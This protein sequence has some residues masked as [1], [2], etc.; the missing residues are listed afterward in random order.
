MK[1]WQIH[2]LVMA[3]V[4]FCTFVIIWIIVAA[5]VCSPPNGS[6]WKSCITI[7]SSPSSLLPVPQTQNG[8]DTMGRKHT[9]HIVCCLVLCVCLEC[10]H[11]HR[12]FLCVSLLWYPCYILGVWLLK[13]QVELVWQLSHGVHVTV[14]CT[15]SPYLWSLPLS[16][17]LCCNIPFK[18]KLSDSDAS[19][20]LE[21]LFKCSCTSAVCIVENNSRILCKFYLASVL[22]ALKL[23]VSSGRE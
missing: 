8:L 20:K 4:I 9:H 21:M 3:V 23:C 6:K 7:P 13:L 19:L 11:D 16:T 2:S 14:T 10:S 22:G 18:R 5:V 17:I 12:F 15:F 1:Q